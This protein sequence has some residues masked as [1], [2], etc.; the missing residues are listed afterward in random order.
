MRT[1]SILRLLLALAAALLLGGTL[2]AAPATSAAPVAP[3][4]KVT[5]TQLAA[6]APGCLP[7]CWGAI[8]FNTQTLRGGWTQK[9]D[10]ATKA[11]AMS[12]ALSH[13]RNRPPNAGHRTA[14]QAPG[15][16]EVVVQNGCVAV[17]W[18]V[19]NERLVEWAKGKAYGPKGA[20]REARRI[21]DGRGTISSG[22]YC[23]PRRF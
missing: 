20:Q 11:G 21:V 16:R 2:L 10:W 17:A 14:C 18:R 22:Y 23:T 12:S 6:R 3:A 8:S 4:E 1:A 9:G 5:T 19:R 7:R 15:Q 13:C